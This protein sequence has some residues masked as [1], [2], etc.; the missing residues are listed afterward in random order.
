MSDKVFSLD[1]SHVK[2]LLLISYLVTLIVDS[3]I[4]IS[5]QANFVPSL[6]L[7]VLLFWS[8][9][10]LNQT[11]LFAAFV[12]GLLFD[13]LANT[14]LGSHGIIFLSV[15]FLMLR[16]RQRFKSYPMWQQSLI[17]S[18]YL[19]LYQIFSWFLFSPVLEGNALLFF[20]IE[21]FLAWIIW[22]ILSNS[23]TRLT[24]RMVFQ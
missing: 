15:T 4:I 1:F 6:T 12:L 24:Q 20:W 18:V 9:K 8:T 16:G 11:H 13:A 3:M 21:P 2:W 5:F 17:I 10:I 19:M 23:M 14:P 7:M 22:P